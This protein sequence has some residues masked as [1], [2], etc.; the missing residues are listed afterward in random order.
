M[1]IKKIDGVG[2]LEALGFAKAGT[3]NDE[4][5]GSRLA[6]IPEKISSEDVPPGF[7]GV[8][9]DLVEADGAVELSDDLP[10]EEMG[11]PGMDSAG[12]ETLNAMDREELEALIEE[13]QLNVP[14]RKTTGTDKLRKLVRD[15]LEQAEAASKRP[16][17]VSTAKRT[18]GRLKRKPQL[19]PDEDEDEEERALLKKGPKKIPR[20]PLGSRL[21][22]IAN[23]V[24]EALGTR[25][26]T[27]REVAK[28]TG[29]PL[30]QVRGRLYYAASRGKLEYRK[31]IKFRVRQKL[32]GEFSK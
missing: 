7:E 9:G 3:W 12:T 15:A 8:Y 24:N 1:K 11:V 22:T 25:W 6:Q 26:M 17:P 14:F 4:K 23:I 21:G 20:D 19:P 13:K 5:L 31:Q 2:L 18:K 28:E 30:S 10:D 29:L 27:D 32:M 16:E